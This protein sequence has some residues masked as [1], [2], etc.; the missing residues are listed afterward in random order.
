MSGGIVYE[1]VK[2]CGPRV[3]YR[4]RAE[5]GTIRPDPPR[6]ETAAWSDTS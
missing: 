4:S 1:I 2:F 3:V 6:E 5:N